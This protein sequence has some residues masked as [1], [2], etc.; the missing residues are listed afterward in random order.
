MKNL[1]KAEQF[2]YRSALGWEYDSG[3]YHV[4]LQKALDAVGYPALRAEQKARQEAFHRGETRELMGIGVCFFTEI[5]G[6]GPS[7]QVDVG[8]RQVADALVISQV[9]VVGDEGRDLG[10][11]I[12]RQ[13][14]VFEQDAVL[15]RLMPAL[16]LALGHR[17]IRRPTQRRKA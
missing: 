17:M 13:V 15:E 4:A 8:W 3:N 9:I 10:F 5:V 12:A 11:E 2:P 1:I 7:R 16:D 14:I 6:A